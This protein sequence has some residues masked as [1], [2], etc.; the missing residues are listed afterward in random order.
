MSRP[1]QVWLLVIALSLLWGSSFL[2]LKRVLYLY[3]PIQVFAGRMLFAGILLVPLAWRGLR[4]IPADKWP[5]LL[6]I[7]I[8]ANFTTT[9]LNA[10][11]QVS[12]ASALAGIL[13]SL[14]PLMT[15]FVGLLFFNQAM[16]RG[17]FW[18]V[19]WGLLGTSLLVLTSSN[20]E[21]GEVDFAAFLMIGAT[22]C[23]AF[24]NHIIRANLA[25]LS[26][27]QVAGASFLLISPVALLAGWS[28]GLFEQVLT[29]PENWQTTIYLAFLGMGANAMALLM[30]ARIVQ[31]SSPVTASMVNYIIPIVAVGWGIYDGESISL[32]QILFTALIIACVWLVN[33]K[34][35]DQEEME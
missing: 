11:A 6:A 10:F 31:L 14:T 19:L 27:M 34:Q 9:L 32:P 17:Q 1:L 12:L 3:S 23:H 5:P 4:R 8:I 35:A 29:Y 24:T 30:V 20:G 7:A 13:N 2:L 26:Y 18:G 15:L 21:F 16:L 33:R 22:L 25:G 28:S